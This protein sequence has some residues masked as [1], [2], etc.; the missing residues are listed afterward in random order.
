MLTL[1]DSATWAGGELAFDD[2]ELFDRLT[3]NPRASLPVIDGAAE[4]V[5]HVGGIVAHGS[6]V[7]TLDVQTEQAFGQERLVRI[8]DLAAH[9]FITDGDDFCRGGVQTECPA[10]CS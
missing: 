2:D 1:R 7:V 8:D 3:A 9:E 6:L 4:G 10:F 5:G